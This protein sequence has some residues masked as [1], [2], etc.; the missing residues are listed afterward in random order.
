[1]KEET[2]LK[3]LQAKAAAAFGV[4]L[5]PAVEPITDQQLKANQDV[6]REAEA[7]IAYINDPRKFIQKECDSCGGTFAVNRGNVARCSDDC[8][9]RWLARRGIIWDPN[10]DPSERWDFREPL[11]ILPQVLS[12]LLENLSH[13]QEVVVHEELQDGL[14]TVE[15]QSDS[16]DDLLN[17]LL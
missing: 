8:R 9:T 16:I 1:M 13:H 15:H 6:S 2:R 7:V 5:P 14:Q 10:K 12:P 3:R 17:S 4:V 11:V